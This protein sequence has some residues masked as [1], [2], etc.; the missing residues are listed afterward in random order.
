MGQPSLVGLVAFGF[1]TLL[2][3]GRGVIPILA[4]AV[5]L[6]LAF[7]G[8][9]GGGFWYLDRGWAILV[10]GWF[11]MMMMMWPT[12]SFLTLALIA[13]AGALGSAGILLSSM[14]GLGAAEALVV[15]RVNNE[16]QAT[17]EMAESVSA[18]EGT[19]AG[20]ELFRSLTEAQAVVLPALGEIRVLLLPALMGLGALASLG[21]AWWMH[22]R[23]TTGSRDGL[24]GIR[25]FR[26]PDP[27]IWVMIVGIV[28]VLAGEWG[29]GYGR[30][31]ANLVAFMGGLYIFRGAGV[32]L[33]LVGSISWLG[34]LAL[35][36]GV[37]FASPF[38]LASAMMVG[39]SDS[40]FDLRARLGG[41]EDGGAG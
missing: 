33:S 13:V 41:R 20:A 28:L 8:E 1:L 32:L 40:W 27:L 19:G 38:L 17:L 39:L 14:G 22:R 29:V 5:A 3:P 26:F 4:T 37:I 2:S 7:I 25:E 31:G 36:A 30:V 23:L 6:G 9:T 16:V 35:L 11:A 15:E 24:G 18:G 10:G 12:G 21:V 34:G